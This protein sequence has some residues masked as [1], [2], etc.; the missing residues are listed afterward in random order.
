MENPFT[1]LYKQWKQ[2]KSASSKHIFGA[3]NQLPYLHRKQRMHYKHYVY[4][5]TWN[6]T[7]VYSREIFKK[8]EIHS[9]FKKQCKTYFCFIDALFYMELNDIQIC[10]SYYKIKPVPV[11]V[12]RV[13]SQFPNSSVTRFLTTTNDEKKYSLN[14]QI[15]I[16]SYLHNNSGN[17]ENPKESIPYSPVLKIK[18]ICYYDKKEIKA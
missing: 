14:K 9:T 12:D 11:K 17:L 5:R 8:G 6:A 1:P 16:N 15:V 2:W 7:T 13:I 10:R 18:K 4:Y 3:Q